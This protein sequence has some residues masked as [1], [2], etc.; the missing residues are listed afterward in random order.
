MKEKIYIAG[1]I[2]GVKRCVY[3]H[4]FSVKEDL[5]KVRGYIVLNP[6]RL[7]EPL[8]LQG[9]EYEDMMKICFTFVDVADVIY[10]MDGWEDSPGA[11]REHER[12]INAG[13]KVIYESAERSKR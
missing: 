4:Q 3:H 5:L 6:V 2:T 11:R 10:M 1:K 9:I 12:A 7:N 13:K 8:A